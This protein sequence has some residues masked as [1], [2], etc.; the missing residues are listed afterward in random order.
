MITGLPPYPFY[1]HLAAA[2]SL[3]YAAVATAEGIDKDDLSASFHANFS[4]NPERIQ[5]LVLDLL[6]PWLTKN[7]GRYQNTRMKSTNTV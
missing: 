7:F 6:R 3:R 4:M 2:A 1:S 5:G